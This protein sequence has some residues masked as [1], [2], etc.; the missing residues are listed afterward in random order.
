MLDWRY[1]GTCAISVAFGCVLRFFQEKKRSKKVDIKFQIVASTIISY[2]SYLLY[3]DRKIDV[4]SIE[5]WL[6]GW[7]YFASYTV[8]ILDQVFVNGWKMYL[9]TLAK[10]FI[11]YTDKTVTNDNDN[12]LQ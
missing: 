3:R 2:V 1:Y 12:D 8:T 9:T 11:A 4:C 7:S 10:R 5:I 6:F